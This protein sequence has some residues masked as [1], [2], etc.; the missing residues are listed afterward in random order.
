MISNTYTDCK[1]KENQESDYEK[2]LYNGY[3]RGRTIQ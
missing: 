2:I 1:T 3:L